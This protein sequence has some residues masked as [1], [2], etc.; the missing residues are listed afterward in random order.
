VIAIFRAGQIQKSG[1]YVTICGTWNLKFMG[2]ESG[3]PVVLMVSNESCRSWL[4]ITCG[5]I[6][7]CY[8]ITYMSWLQSSSSLYGKEKRQ[9]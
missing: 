5:S 4:S 7:K 6:A 2:K 1:G 3:L 9:Q 8:T